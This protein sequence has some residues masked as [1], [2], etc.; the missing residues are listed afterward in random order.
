M[1]SNVSAEL[2][3]RYQKKC[4]YTKAGGERSEAKTRKHYLDSRKKKCRGTAFGW[5]GELLGNILSVKTEDLV[6]N[7]GSGK[8]GGEGPKNQF[9]IVANWGWL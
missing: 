9:G 8:V 3:V 4:L 1:N 2:M 6:Q 5:G 7:L